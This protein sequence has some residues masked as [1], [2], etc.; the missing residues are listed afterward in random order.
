MFQKLA[1]T[2]SFEALNAPSFQVALGEIETKFRDWMANRP[3]AK[4]CH[5]NVA[6][7]FKRA[8]EAGG[9]P[10]LLS[11][12]E[13]RKGSDYYFLQ[14]GGRVFPMRVRKR[15]WNPTELTIFE[16]LAV[17]DFS[18]KKFDDGGLSGVYGQDLDK[19]DSVTVSREH[20]PTTH[21]RY[22]DGETFH[23]ESVGWALWE[24]A[25]ACIRKTL[26][27]E[28]AKAPIRRFDVVLEHDVEVVR[29][30][31]YGRT[32]RALL[33]SVGREV[34]PAPLS[35]PPA[36]HD[37][38]G[39]FSWNGR[40]VAVTSERPLAGVAADP[41]RAIKVWLHTRQPNGTLTWTELP[42]PA[43]GALPAHGA[44]P[45]LDGNTLR[46]LGGVGA[47][48]EPVRTHFAYDLAAGERDRH[49]AR[50][51]RQEVPL[52]EAVAW[53]AAVALERELLVAGGVAGFYVKAAE[54]RGK[55]KILTHRRDLR[56]LGRNGWKKRDPLK[57][58]LT[59]AHAVFG[60]GCAF[61]GPGNAMTGRL[62]AYDTNDDGAAIELPR[63]PKELG[64]GQLLLEGSRLVY[65]GGFEKNGA[66]STGI[67]ELDLEELRPAW[68][69]LG[70]SV[71]AQGAA[72]V[73]ESF[74]QVLSLMVAPGRSA[75]YPVEAAAPGAGR[76]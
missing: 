42:G 36:A 5:E 72:R 13:G 49:A 12:E 69:K 14:L 41:G 47:D 28:A 52:D 9:A 39:A 63:L 68:K 1:S 25:S 54:D 59:G 46:I 31:R 51:W 62:F 30:D 66:P 33:G 76:R 19:V 22:K 74:G 15:D 20:A 58:E 65:A 37:L 45:V 17:R 3:V 50:H 2:R 27:E 34:G 73:V 75:A 11:F 35:G 4:R 23:D 61:I 7:P 71:F 26:A 32:T 29:P 53:P 44:T 10:A 67:Y 40:A 43:N 24:T 56:A 57:I 18:R 8:L 48:G 60:R 6:L 64:L 21:I 38:L 70:D 55:P 16:P